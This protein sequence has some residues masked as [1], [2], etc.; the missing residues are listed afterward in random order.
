MQKI[1]LDI[2]ERAYLTWMLQNREIDVIPKITY[3]KIYDY[4]VQEMRIVDKN[5]IFKYHKNI[6]NLSELNRQT[7]Y[8]VIVSYL[9]LF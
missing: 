5:K 1:Y 2:V 7:E 6:V 9:R 8:Y 3:D 4:L